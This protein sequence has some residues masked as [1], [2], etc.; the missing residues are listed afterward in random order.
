[1]ALLLLLAMSQGLK[2]LRRLKIDGMDATGMAAA[3]TAIG[4]GVMAYGVLFL[5]LGGL[6]FPWVI[7]AWLAVLFWISRAELGEIIV[8]APLWAREA[9]GNFKALEYARKG[10][11]LIIAGILGLNMLQALTPPWGYDALMYHL[12]APRLFLEGG[13]IYLLP[14]V[15]QANGPLTIEMIYT[16]GLA[17]GSDVFARLVHLSFLGLMFAGTF[18]LGRRLIGE[19]GGWLA[20]GILAGIPILPLWGNLAYSDM[21]LALF[22]LMTILSLAW[23]RWES[24]E[25]FLGLAG[26]FLGLAMGSKYTTLGMTAVVVVWIMLLSLR[27][28]WKEAF[29]AGVGTAVP[30]L[31]VA[32]PWYIKNWALAGNPVFPF[33][34]GGPGWTADRLGAVNDYLLEAFGT[35]RSLWDYLMLPYNLYTQ[36]GEFGTY[37]STIEIPSFLFPL[38]FLYPIARRYANLDSFIVLTLG[39]FGS[40]ALGSQQTRFLIPIYP[41]L[42]V[43]SSLSLLWLGTKIQQQFIK[44]AF[45]VGLVG[46]FVMVTLVYQVI[47]QLDVFPYPVLIGSESKSSFLTR[48]LYDYPAMQFIEE[49]ISEDERVLMMW[50]GQG[51]YCD[52]RCI[53][54]VD[55]TRLMRLYQLELSPL[56]LASKLINEGNSHILIDV[57]GFSFF[58]YYDVD[59]L[60]IRASRYFFERFIPKCG[61]EVFRDEKVI[62]FEIVCQVGME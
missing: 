31:L 28:G 9:W 57:E 41:L 35:G 49:S 10:L 16:I 23:W 6:L 5:G 21:S 22:F 38:V 55:Q 14:D 60:H 46:G 24:D 26:I 25:R 34:F 36:H 11:I 59:G 43:F 37:F 42:C 12:Q 62:I 44:R 18:S 48:E 27:T 39:L 20:L 13:R 51:Y 33:Y 3:S 17:T 50:D 15:W 32:S 61:E 45:A 7:F 4:F 1:M 54:D 8:R 40:W 19:T 56:E 30:A 53:P 58:N 29:R 47:H 2:V 52:E